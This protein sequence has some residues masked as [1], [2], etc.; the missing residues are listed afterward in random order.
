MEIILK[1]KIKV[2][3]NN[4]KQCAKDCQKLDIVL[5]ECT[6]FEKELDGKITPEE[7]WFRCDECIKKEKENVVA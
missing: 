1:I 7:I 2:D 3:D 6:L 5:D 4:H